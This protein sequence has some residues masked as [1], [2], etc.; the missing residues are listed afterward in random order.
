MSAVRVVMLLAGKDLRI[1]ARGRQTLG[2]VVV[3]GILIEVVLA[4][5]LG[6]A[7]SGLRAT[8]ILWVT[9]LFGGVLCFEKTMA[10]ERQHGAMAGL[11][12]APVDRGLIYL[13]KLCANLALLGAL[14]AVVTPVG[15]VFFGFDL[16]AA[17][18]AFAAVIG[19][20][21]VGYAAVGTLFSA[22]T[23]AS[24]LQGG[25]LAMVVFPLSLPLVIT[26]TQVLAGV[27]DRGEALDMSGLGV[28]AVF[29]VIFLTASW[30]VFE[31]VVEP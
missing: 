18:G 12:L 31:L 22:V 15:I 4:L 30:S 1:E 13:G 11:L 10:V 26:S 25:L 16:S 6:Q 20:S 9:Y 7:S 14:A 3:L 28:I 27:M 23:S 8:A 2:L 24:R 5:G 17:P 29:D 21:L 19:L